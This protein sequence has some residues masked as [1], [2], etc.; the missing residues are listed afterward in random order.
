MKLRNVIGNIQGQVLQSWV[1]SC[2]AMTLFGWFST[3]KVP[4][5]GFRG[6]TK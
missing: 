6:E 3:V 2:L 5:R 1:A 4:F